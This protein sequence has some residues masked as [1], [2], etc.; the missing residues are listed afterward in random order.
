MD[1][2]KLDSLIKEINLGL[3]YEYTSQ[4]IDCTITRDSVFAL[5][6]VMDDVY[7]FEWSN[8]D[9]EVVVSYIIPDGESVDVMGRGR[10]EDVLY[11]KDFYYLAYAV[12]QIHSQVI[13][14]GVAYHFE[15]DAITVK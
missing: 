12:R 4:G 10:L 3:G 11:R 15:K 14:R 6:C 8:M 2:N 1:S 7:S 13:G 9:K 5:S